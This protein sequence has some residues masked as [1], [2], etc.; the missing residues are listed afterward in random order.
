MLLS[1]KVHFFLFTPARLVQR[2]RS[3]PRF[4]A[5]WLGK[6][7]AVRLASSAACSWLQRERGVFGPLAIVCYFCIMQGTY[8]FVCQC[9]ARMALFVNTQSEEDW[10]WLQLFG[11]CARGHVAAG[12]CMNTAV[13]VKSS[14]TRWCSCTLFWMKVSVGKQD[15]SSAAMLPATGREA[16]Q[17]VQLG[18]SLPSLHQPM[19]LA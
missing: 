2:M 13:Q 11:S 1:G 5:D 4:W 6:G 9:W 15:E 18:P 12:V 7:G 16:V 17:Y 8:G 3:G 14:C 19:W 10:R